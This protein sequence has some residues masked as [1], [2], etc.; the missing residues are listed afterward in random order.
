[1]T[2]QTP[3]PFIW[4]PPYQPPSLAYNTLACCVAAPFV[5]VAYYP[6]R[7]YAKSYGALEGSS[8]RYFV[9]SRWRGMLT[10]PEIPLLVS[11]PPAATLITFLAVDQWTGSAVLPS[12]ACGI[13]SGTTKQFV[14]KYSVNIGKRR[15]FHGEF[16]YKNPWSCLK[17]VTKE[18][19]MGYWLQGSMA[20][21]LLHTMWFGAALRSMRWQ[22]VSREQRSFYEDVFIALRTV[23]LWSVV[24]APLRNGVMD[25]T[26][27]VSST[28]SGG[29]GGYLRAGGPEFWKNEVALCLDSARRFQ[30]IAMSDGFFAM[31]RGTGLLFFKTNVPFALTF[32]TYRLFGGGF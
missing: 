17:T 27:I 25:V 26:R 5:T 4:S 6:A 20:N 1:M 10:A 19:G 32:A 29:A 13:V 9:T 8:L 30:R 11:L 16:A 15:N 18:R 14:R 23:T 21:S 31:F 28:A 24:T 12:V 3:S 2:A 7:D 22:M